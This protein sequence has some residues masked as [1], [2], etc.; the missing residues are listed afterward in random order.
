MAMELPPGLAGYVAAQQ[1]NQQGQLG[2]LQQAQALMGLQ[3]Q[4]Q[5]AQKARQYEAALQGLGPNPSGDALAQVAA[6]YAGPEKALDVMQRSQDRQ[7]ALLN[8]PDNRPEILRLVDVARQLPPEDPRH[9]PIQAR[10]KLLSERPDKATSG[11][12]LGKLIAE[13]DAL[14]EGHADR[15]IYDAAITKFQPGGVQVTVHPNAPLIPGKTGQNKVDEG[16][17]DT[18]MRLQRLSAIESQFKPEYQQ[19]APRLS[20]R[21]SSVKEK[22]GADLDPND[23]KFLT[24]FS[25]YKR[26]SINSM[27]E[28]IKSITGAAMSEAEAQRILKGMP[29]PGEGVFDGDSPTEFKAKMDDAI[30]QTRL[31]EARLVYIKRNG[32]SIGDVT[33]DRMPT[34]MNERGSALETAIKKQQPQI[35]QQDLRKLVRRNLAQEFGLVE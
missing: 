33:L 26:N 17:L 10:I 13:R 23:S 15:K 2:Q 29:N 32:M 21:W 1:Q 31:A 4:M 16:L 9:A 35:N 19:I 22:L 18:G 34:L 5:Q 14:P 24:E 6:R 3:G 28:Y 12:A 8:R 30:K 25:S 20:A 7:T 27:N 11:S